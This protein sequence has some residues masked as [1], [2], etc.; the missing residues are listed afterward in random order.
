MTAGSMNRIKK[1]I[2]I[3]FVLVFSTGA[4]A[5]DSSSKLFDGF[6]QNVGSSFSGTNLL[7]HGAGFA[8]TSLI[9]ETGFDAKVYD[10]FRHSPNNLSWP[11]AVLGS[12]A[13]ALVA[14]SWLY[15]SGQNNKN[16]KN[17]GAA[18]VIAQ[19]SII[20]VSYVSLVKITTGRAR[21]TNTSSLSS[22]EQSRERQSALF[23]GGV[24]YGWP[25][26]H[27][28]HTTA[29]SSALA[30][31]Y[32]EHPW[33]RWMSVG[34]VSYMLYTVSAHDSAQ[35]HWFSDG[36]AGAFSGYAIGS[37]VGK[38]S[39]QKIEGGR[40]ESSALTWLPV[41]GP[42]NVGAMAAYQF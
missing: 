39:R 8:S 5:Q 33:L 30:H 40:E 31:Y 13:G 3:A 12:G 36:V 2:L 9:V 26:G 41:L 1:S 14:G 23:R 21:P 20:T 10:T 6:W 17:V 34:L 22:Q 24:S 32:P 7:Y 15:F 4:R 37:S 27:V 19:A 25:S 29:V 38:N 35:M 16:N 42:R 18:F 11:G 28:S